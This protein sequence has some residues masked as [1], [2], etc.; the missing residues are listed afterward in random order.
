MG[1]SSIVEGTNGPLATAIGGGVLA[2]VGYLTTDAIGGRA[3]ILA[4][5]VLFVGAVL[6]LRPVREPR[7]HRL[8]PAA[9]STPTG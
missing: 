9:V 5:L 3:A 7:R 8:A 6:L 2:L 4:G 1:M